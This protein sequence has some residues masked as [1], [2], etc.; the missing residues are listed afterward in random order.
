MHKTFNFS[1]SDSKIKALPVL[2]FAHHFT[3]MQNNKAPLHAHDFWQLEII[4]SGSVSV[5]SGASTLKISNGGCVLIPKGVPHRFVYEQEREV[6][7]LKFE[8]EAENLPKSLSKIQ[9]SNLSENILKEMLHILN[10]DSLRKD[11]SLSLPWLL[12]LFFELAFQ[13]SHDNYHGANMAEKVKMFINEHE[14]RRLTV[15]DVA[16]YLGVSRN[17]ISKLFHDKT[18]LPLKTYIDL[19]R[20]E[21]AKEILKFSNMTISEIS[22]IMEF[23]DIY[24]FS[25]FFSRVAEISPSEFR[26][27]KK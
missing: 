12:G 23:P 13:A 18:G 1:A 25:K 15:D 9:T 5:E 14:G 17:T 8:M 3:E 26:A 24:A 21:I 4:V 27:S 20:M 11:A 22:R 6:W 7:S 10:S 16:T 19:R 2:L